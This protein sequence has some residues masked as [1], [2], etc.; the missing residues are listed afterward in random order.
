MSIVLKVPQFNMFI[1]SPISTSVKLAVATTF[2]GAQVMIL[3]MDNS[4]GE[5][6]KVKGMNVSWISKYREED[7][8]CGDT[9]FCCA[10]NCL[11]SDS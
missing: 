7:E 1:H 8:R 5:C 9:S 3:E 11:L 2:S 6:T 4:G 10:C